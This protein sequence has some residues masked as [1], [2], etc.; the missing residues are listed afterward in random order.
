[1]SLSD[2][3]TR[4]VELAAAA[5]LRFPPLE[6]ALVAGCRRPTIRTRFKLGAIALGYVRVLKKRELRVAEMRSYRFFVNVAEPLGIAPFFFEDPGTVWL[7][8]ELIRPGD[9]C[10]DAGA[11]VGHYT[12]LAA[13]RV[14]RTGRVYAFESNPEC[15]KIIERSIQLNQFD[16]FVQVDL[17]ALW[18]EDGAEMSFLVS[19]N[20]NNTGTS[21][22]IDHGTFVSR[23]HSI[24]VK[25]L[26]LDSFA[27]AESIAR[28][29]LLK[30]DVERAEA[31]VLQGA[32]RLLSE[33][34][35][36]FLI[37]EM[38]A[39]SESHELLAAKG[40]RGFFMDAE[41][42]RL[43]PLEEIRGQRFGDL[44]YVSETMMD[45]F[46]STFRKH[47]APAVGTG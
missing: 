42:K 46:P 7:A 22:L 17:H 25:T 12:F 32:T 4:A 18:N 35:I 9:I 47:F 31:Q 20:P 24:R 36:D 1:M 28:I 15:A 13:S 37:V 41:E 26:T 29:R 14:G 34:R 27:S 19:T 16:S 45:S 10:I 3:K 44:L 8:Q 23:E 11:N 2:L 30:I 33:G 39:V 6:R 38:Y 43:I 21:S 5:S 40:Y